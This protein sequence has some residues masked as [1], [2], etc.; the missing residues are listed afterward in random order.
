MAFGI[1]RIDDNVYTC[2]PIPGK[3]YTNTS[4]ETPDWVLSPEGEGGAKR[5]I[6]PLPADFHYYPPPMQPKNDN[7]ERTEE[8]TRLPIPE[9][10]LIA[11]LANGQSGDQQSQ[12][13]ARE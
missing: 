8:S 11:E 7:D 5:I 3:L 2:E 12:P 13:M 10:F 9:G 1:P 4:G 6:S